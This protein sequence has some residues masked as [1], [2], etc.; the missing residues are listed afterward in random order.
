MITRHLPPIAL[1]LALVAG[2]A[3]A[4]CYHNDIA[5]PDEV[6]T[7]TASPASI[8]ADGFSTTRITAT[9]S[10]SADR[11]LGLTFTSTAAGTITSQSMSPDASGQV[12][13]FL[14]STTTPQNV[15]V[16][17][18][19][20][21]GQTVIASRTVQVVFA[22]VDSSTIVKLTLSS[23][24]LEADGA[25]SIQVRG[26]INPGVAA[27]SVKFDTTNGS[28]TPGSTAR[29][30]GD[31]PTDANGTARVLLYAPTDLGTALVTV[32]GG[33]FSTSD[34]VSFVP[35]NP[36][37][38][39]LS[40]GPLTIPKTETQVVTVTALLSRSPGQ[41]TTN[42]SVDFSIVS[43]VTGQTFG[44]FQN[45]KR[46]GTDRQ[47][48]ADFVPGANAPSGLATITAT[49]PGKV[50]GTSLTASVKITIQ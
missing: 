50:P 19:V 37:A 26:D 15:L 10:P 32:T 1:F 21:R 35:A 33:T 3:S 11:S 40:A 39:S 48:S 41:V 47:A 13:T 29:T 36:D 14:K 46:S 45:V 18:N 20:N 17:V 31:I 24:E 5:A 12:S 49:V 7:I 6:L 30:S 23:H 38:I 16:T 22:P 4:A 2:G 44:R 43:D 25:S 8:P 28:F 42:T 34:T 9:V 27:H